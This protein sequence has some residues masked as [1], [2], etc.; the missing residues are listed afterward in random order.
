MRIAV[1]SDIHQSTYWKNIIGQK[2]DFDKIIFLGDEFDT[3]KNLWPAQMIN[4]E[5][6]IAFKNENIEKVDLC[7]SNHA[8]SYFLDERC[9]GYQ[10]K[11]SLLIK[12]F[13]YEYKNLY[14]VI[15]IYDNWIF[16]HAGVSAKW[17]RCSGISDIN[18]INRLF[19]E[20]PVFFKWV[21]PDG[22]GNNS[23]EGPLW[24][25]P[26]SLVENSVAD[27]HQAA[28]HSENMQPKIVKKYKQ[29]FVFCD[30]PD[31]NYLTV[32]DTKSN[33]V[34]FIYMTEV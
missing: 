2:D 15:Y 16:S 8:I 13:Y 1:I 20:K 22:Y 23:N 5:E 11:C 17:M 19:R 4:A 24:I 33:S 14:N 27:M 29:L 12:E 21:G 18:E 25:R 28:G 26:E 3:W 32:I 31:H 10:S 34:E 9:S 6:I 7:W 30:T